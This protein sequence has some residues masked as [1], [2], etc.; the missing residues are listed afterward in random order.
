MLH[1][2]YSGSI[3][4]VYIYTV[5]VVFES[6]LYLTKSFIVTRH[7]FF[8]IFL[9]Q[10]LIAGV[11]KFSGSVIDSQS[12]SC[13]LD[14]TVH[15][16]STSNALRTVSALKVFLTF[17]RRQKTQK[18]SNIT[19]CRQYNMQ[20]HTKTIYIHEFIHLKY[21]FMDSFKVCISKGFMSFEKKTFKYQV[22]HS[23][24]HFLDTTGIILSNFSNLMATFKT[25]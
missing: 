7:E 21:L 16:P 2:V 5:Q 9:N 3:V 20:K 15:T 8:N 23:F 13:V 19:T 12:S 17:I 11:A 25:M 6:V 14:I 1:K 24:Q 4:H 18:M 10:Y 22:F